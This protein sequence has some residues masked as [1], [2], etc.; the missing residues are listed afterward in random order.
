AAIGH[1]LVRG[2]RGRGLLIGIV[3]ADPVAKAVESGCRDAG[4]LVNAVTADVIRIAPPLVVTSADLDRF[5]A[6]LP[7]VLDGAAATAPTSGG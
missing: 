5:V 3:L 4:F 6:A 7:A 2:V 1:P